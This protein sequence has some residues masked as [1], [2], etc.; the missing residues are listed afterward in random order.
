MSDPPGRAQGWWRRPGAILA[1]L[2]LLAVAVRLAPLLLP[3]EFEAPDSPG[4]LVPAAHLARG[5]GYLGADGLPATSRPP[6]YPT[7]VALAFLLAGGPSPLAVQLLQALLGAAG[8]A[9]VFEVLRR[10]A[11]GDGGPGPPLLGAALFALDP[12]AV[13]QSPWLLREALLMAGVAALLAALLALPRARWPVA[14]L[15]LALLALTHPLYLL[16]GPALALTHALATPGARARA[17]VLGAWLLVGAVVAAPVLGWA[18]RNQRVT[19]RLAL[20]IEGNTVPARELWLT[21]E[22]PNLW[23]SGDPATGFQALAFAEERA[24]I[25]AVGVEAARA[26]LYRRA[27]RNWREHP[28]RTLGRLARQNAWYWLELPGA[29][30]LVEHPRLFAL[31]WLLLPFH[32]V[33]LACALAAVVW[34]VRGGGWRRAWPLLG[35]LGFFA[36]APALLYP[37]PRYLAPAC[38]ALDALALLGLL[39]ARPPRAGEPT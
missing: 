20:A 15:L 32:W 16:L 31:R 39:A 3:V 4:Y 12:I 30:R 23:L 6:G 1:A 33:R 34:L 8:T 29:I 38:P 18:W 13:G 2:C 21:T 24:L 14:G 9:A 22:C 19:G 7:F 5:A 17:R 27:G 36:L 26:E 28:L 35:A 25:E 11:P 37:I 10:L